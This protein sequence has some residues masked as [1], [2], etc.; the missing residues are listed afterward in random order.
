[1]I[2]TRAAG[3]PWETEVDL[4]D[5]DLGKARDAR[6]CLFGYGG[7]LGVVRPL[8]DSRGRPEDACEEVPKECGELN[9]SH[10]YATWAEIAA[11]DW[12]APVCD[13]ADP[14]SV[15]VWLP[16]PDGE[17]VLDHVV[18]TPAEVDDAAR[19]L[20]GEDLYPHEWPPGGEVRL[21]RAVYRPLVHTARTIVPPD[22]A[23][24]PVWA[25]MRTLAAQYG[26]ENV[27]LVVWFG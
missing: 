15:G 2:E 24:A 19:E 10:S 22:G 12:D 14:Y 27:R 8:F 6:E 16:G 18:R 9:H 26:D 13:R 4:L 1:M 11:V 17:P 20:F 7:G 3:E 23:W 21:D 5:F 25:S